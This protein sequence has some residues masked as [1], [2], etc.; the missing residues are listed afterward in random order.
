MGPKATVYRRING[1]PGQ[2]RCQVE[3]GDYYFVG[4]RELMAEGFGMWGWR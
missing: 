2:E 1:R 4:T 3:L